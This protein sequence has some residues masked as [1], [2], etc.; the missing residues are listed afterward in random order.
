MENQN[1]NWP[2]SRSENGQEE[3]SDDE[4]DDAEGDNDHI[5]DI[6]SPPVDSHQPSVSRREVC[7]RS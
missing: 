2:L 6:T 1:D 3:K 7:P 5:N 4:V